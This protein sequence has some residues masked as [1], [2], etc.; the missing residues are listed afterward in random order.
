[1]IFTVWQTIPQMGA[2]YLFIY[3]KI[4]HEV[5]DRQTYNKNNENSKSSIKRQH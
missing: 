5:H 3:Y 1:M 2:I 4:V